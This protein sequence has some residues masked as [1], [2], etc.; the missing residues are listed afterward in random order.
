MTLSPEQAREIE[1]GL[2]R[3]FQGIDR[4]HRWAVFRTELT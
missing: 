2:Q 3:R 4:A 1:I